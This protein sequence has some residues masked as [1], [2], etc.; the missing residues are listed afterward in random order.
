MGPSPTLRLCPPYLI[1]SSA[2]KRS[3]GGN[4]TPSCLRRLQIDDQLERSLLDGQ[5]S[6]LDTVQD[7]VHKDGRALAQRAGVCPIGQQAPR[8]G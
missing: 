1:T 7:L 6:R 5:V 3:V 2:R 4:V 8:L